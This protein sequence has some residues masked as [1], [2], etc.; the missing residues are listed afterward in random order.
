MTSLTFNPSPLGNA[1]AVVLFQEG[2]Q[3]EDDIDDT[4]L[5]QAK[6]RSVRTNLLAFVSSMRPLMLMFE[7]VLTLALLPVPMPSMLMLMLIHAA[8]AGLRQS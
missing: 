8:A 2:G 7:P 4:A 6:R 3:R 1:G 5:F